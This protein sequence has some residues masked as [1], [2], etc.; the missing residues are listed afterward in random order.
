MLK[1]CWSS[2]KVLSILCLLAM[3]MGICAAVQGQDS[4]P[5]AETARFLELRLREPEHFPL[6]PTTLTE[7]VEASKGFLVWRTETVDSRTSS[8]QT[9]EVSLVMDAAG[10]PHIA[11]TASSHNELRYA[12]YDGI[13]WHIETVDDQ[14]YP[15]FPTLALDAADQPHI[16][17]C[18]S[19]EDVMK[20]ARYDGFAWHIESLY[21]SSYL[22][23]NLVHL[24]ANRALVTPSE[25]CPGMSI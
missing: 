13:T 2:R 9:G 12:Y 16:A 4:E 25:L 15:R 7:N 10:R 8:P 22:C 21:G 24:G 6:F 18:A 14:S 1:L 3:L 23:W 19:G 5:D 20:Y 17:Y 11:Y